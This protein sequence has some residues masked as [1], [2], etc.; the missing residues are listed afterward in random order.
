ML[1][2]SARGNNASVD[3]LVGD[4]YGGRDYSNIGLA[5]S[6]IAS[7]FGKVVAQ[8]RREHQSTSQ[9]SPTVNIRCSSRIQPVV[10]PYLA[11]AM[12]ISP[13]HSSPCLFILYEALYSWWH[14]A[15]PRGCCAAVSRSQV[16]QRPENRLLTVLTFQDMD[17]SGCAPEDCA[18]SLLRMVSYNI[19]QLAYLNAKRYGLKRIFFGGFFIRGLPYTM[20]TLSYAIKFWSKASARM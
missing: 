13:S 8:V 6:T 10:H 4:I 20:E 16:M 7:S 3:M 19:G 15:A 9:H 18:M 14:S 5:A 17:L 2:L 11:V 12:S 1:E